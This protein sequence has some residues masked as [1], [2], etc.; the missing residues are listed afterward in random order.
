MSAAY[1]LG[2]PVWASDRWLGSLYTS[3]AR[4]DEWLAQYSRVFNTVEGNSTFY[5]LPSHG[6]VARW[7]NSVEAG[8][9][10]ALKFPRTISH[11]KRLLNAEAE[12]ESF[13][14]LL[15]ILDRSACLGPSFL[16]LP[17]GFSGH[18]LDDLE[19]YLN[20]LPRDYP[21]AVELR[22]PDFFDRGKTEDALNQMLAGLAID[23]VILDSRPLF[24]GPPMDEYER[25]SQ[26][27]KP[28]TPVHAVIT[29]RYPMI[30]LIGRNDLQRVTPWV[31]EWSRVVAKWL[32]SG[33][34]PFVFA[35][36]PDEKF[37]PHF[38]RKF[39]EELRR[40]TDLAGELAPWPG[41]EQQD[42]RRQL[43]LF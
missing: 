16:Q 15:Q 42:D 17:S 33:L 8:F 7:A 30:R 11:E 6:T 21:Y 29:G 43:R 24:N 40:H 38:A 5:G 1:Y 31:V 3:R 26:A 13:L 19:R 20:S 34:E 22:H 2:C 35:H 28:R 23:R 37:A 27:R 41:E 4:R 10:Y 39:H 12:T 25:E 32:N 9:R 14:K 36:T 18:H